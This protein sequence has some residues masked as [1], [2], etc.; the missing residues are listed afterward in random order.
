MFTRADKIKVFAFDL[1]HH[2][3]H[4]R[5]AHNARY[6]VGTDHV[7]R[8]AVGEAAVDHEISC[9]CQNCRVQTCDIAHQ[10][11]ETVAGDI[12]RGVEVDAVGSV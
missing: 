8:N 4:F 10:I 1:I 3:F 5:K 2:R 6:N 7:G 9:I 11:I 12:A